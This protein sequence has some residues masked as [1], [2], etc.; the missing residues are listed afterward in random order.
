[1]PK[2]FSLSLAPTKMPF[3]WQRW[4]KVLGGCATLRDCIAPIDADLNHPIAI[5]R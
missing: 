5:V 1:M 2:Q 4:L 3:Q